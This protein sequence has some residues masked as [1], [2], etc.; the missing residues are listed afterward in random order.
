MNHG[1]SSSIAK[2]EVFIT[3][4]EKSSG[5]GKFKFFFSHHEE[6]L[7]SDIECKLNNHLYYEDFV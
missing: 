5:L 1:N 4:R 2:N 7:S 6:N 3:L